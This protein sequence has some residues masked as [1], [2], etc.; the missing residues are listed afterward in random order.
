VEFTFDD[1]QKVLLEVFPGPGDGDGGQRGPLVPVAGGGRV[2]R[3]AGAA[4]RQVLKPLVPVLESVHGT[5][6]AVRPRPESVTVELAVKI[7]SD[8]QLGIVSG[9]SEASFTVAAT[10]AL[11]PEASGAPAALGTASAAGTA[12]APGTA[13]SPAPAAAPAAGSPGGP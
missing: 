12:D 1:G 11:G 9:N 7:S 8:L 3:A 4:L 10:W 13:G 5:V 6:S 2:A